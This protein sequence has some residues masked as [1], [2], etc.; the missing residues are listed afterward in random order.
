V[1]EG[2]LSAE[3]VAALPGLG[4][5][6]SEPLAEGG[7][8]H[9]ARLAEVGTGQDALKAAFARDLSLRRFELKEPTLHDAFIV[10]TG[11]QA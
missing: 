10:L 7:W 3:E 8:R 11:G 4:E 2:D 5:V 9:V 1:L 6:V